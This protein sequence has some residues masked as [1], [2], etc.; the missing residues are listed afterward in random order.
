MTS[1]L[2]IGP[3]LV[4]LAS[5]EWRKKEVERL[6]QLLK[7]VILGFWHFGEE[8]DQIFHERFGLTAMG[9]L[10]LTSRRVNKRRET[11][12]GC[13]SSSPILCSHLDPIQISLGLVWHPHLKFLDD[14]PFMTSF[15]KV[16]QFLV[17]SLKILK[18]LKSITLQ[19]LKMGILIHYFLK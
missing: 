10:D 5:D 8:G 19:L 18:S 17:S 15:T 16:C 6:L 11:C 12:F 7:K 2:P 13:L 1:S 14:S 9:S 3:P 4:I